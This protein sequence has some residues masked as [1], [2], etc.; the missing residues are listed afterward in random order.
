MKMTEMDF[1]VSENLSISPLY[2]LLKL[3]PS[4]GV[5]PDTRPGQFVQV[6]VANSKTTFLR[7]PISICY[8]DEEK[9]QL[10]LL[11]RRAGEGTAALLETKAGEKVNLVM[12]LGNG[13]ST[14]FDGE[15]LL[16][17][18]GVGVAPLLQLGKVLN[19]MGKKVRFL[20]GARSKSDLLLLDEFRRWGEVYVSTEDGSEGERGFVTQHSILGEKVDHIACCG[21]LPM[22][23]AVAKIAQEKGIDCEVSLENMMACGLGACLCCVED[24]ADSGH[25][26][27]CKEG[28]VFNISRL[29][30]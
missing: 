23:K 20:L 24:T 11:V 26:C 3:T 28:P 13:F 6:E 14:S 22:M 12:P 5:M 29:K 15:M 2:G 4:T 27:V 16:I 8:V 18:G 9:G 1:I 7:R 10:W 19:K 30:W 17:G 25:V 21:P